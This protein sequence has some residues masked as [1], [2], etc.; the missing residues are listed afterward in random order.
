[1]ENLDPHALVTLICL[2][3]GVVVSGLVSLFKRWSFVKNN[4]K[5]VAFILS[6][7]ITIVGGLTLWGLDW[8]AIVACTLVPF[9]AAVTTHEM[10]H[11]VVKVM[12]K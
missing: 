1:M 10:K 11:E 12:D 8:T 4:I 6:S 3:A 2:V 7:A 9:S 5:L